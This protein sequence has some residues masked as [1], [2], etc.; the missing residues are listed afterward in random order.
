MDY[1]EYWIDKFSTVLKGEGLFDY[2]VESTSKE[3]A[4]FKAMFRNDNV[5]KEVSVKIVTDDFENELEMAKLLLENKNLSN[6]IINVIKYKEGELESKLNYLLLI[7]DYYKEGDLRKFINK[8][9]ENEFIPPILIFKIIFQI[10]NALTV[11]HNFNTEESKKIIHRD[12]KLENVFIEE[13]DKENLYI[14]IRLGDFGEAKIIQQT[15]SSLQHGTYG[16]LP[17]EINSDNVQ[18]S[19]KCDIWSL[20]VL[21]LRLITKDF[22]DNS[23]ELYGE[24][25]QINLLKKNYYKYR[26]IDCLELFK[27][28]ILINSPEKYLDKKKELFLF[29]YFYTLKNNQHDSKEILHFLRDNIILE[30]QFTNYE[31]SFFY[32]LK[33]LNY[34]ILQNDDASFEAY[35]NSIR[36]FKN[37]NLSHFEISKMFLKVRPILEFSPVWFARERAGVAVKSLKRILYIVQDLLELFGFFTSI[38]VGYY[39]LVETLKN[40]Y[41]YP[42]A[43]E[44]TLIVYLICVLVL[45]V[46]Y[47]QPSKVKYLN[48]VNKYAMTLGEIGDKKT[49]IELMEQVYPWLKRKKNKEITEKEKQLSEEAKKIMTKLEEEEN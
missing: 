39:K 15:I 31:I 48:F 20:G 7:T 5:Q 27:N 13:F 43:S 23:K 14:K 12:I 22:K 4:V 26:S 47:L 19:T 10:N 34:K 40:S 25:T 41:L 3:R 30:N 8:Y 2:Q 46:G 1:S 17:P 24:Y 11:I 44:F 33:G 6:N 29:C 18:W 16:Y 9:Y 45:L 49:A 37:N 35:L 38:G 36:Y 21:L 32:F 42:K 28:I